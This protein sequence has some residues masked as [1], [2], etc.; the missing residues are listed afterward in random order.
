[1]PSDERRPNIIERIGLRLADGYIREATGG[2]IDTDEHLWRRIS[3]TRRQLLPYEIDRAQ[4]ISRHLYQRNPMAKRVVDMLVDFTIGAD[5]LTFEAE[6]DA[7][8][9]VIDDFW[10]DPRSNWAMRHRDVVRDL[11]IHG[12]LALRRFV[13]TQSG[14][15]RLGYIDVGRIKSVKSDPDDMLVDTTLVLARPQQED[16]VIPLIVWTDDDGDGRWEGDAFYFAVNRILGE[17]RGVPDLF[18][19]ADYVDGYDQI[20]FNA[21]ERSG[22]INAF[23]YDVT[24]EG[25]TPHDIVEWEEDNRE[26]PPP[27]S[28]RVHNEKEKWATVSPSL[29]SEDVTKVGRAVKNM[30]L[31]GAGMPE[32][33]FAEGDSA[34]RATLAAQGDPTYRMLQS[35][36]EF[37]AD[38]FTRIVSV[39]VQEEV[40]RRIPTNASVEFRV[41]LPE[42]SAKDTSSV[43]AAL[44]QLA[45][46][47]VSAVDSEF[48][49][50]ASARSLF[51][52]LASQVGVDLDPAE[53]EAAIESER[54]DREAKQAE[55]DAERARFLAQFA[56]D[57]E[58]RPQ[59]GD[60]G[61]SGPKA[62]PT[63]PGAP[64]AE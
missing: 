26:P 11:S 51:L 4:S 55:Q 30:G 10:T 29:G 33:W 45:A 58:E 52:T 62:P 5:G 8:Q 44:P 16:E 59:D 18:A 24:L 27:G 41:N 19:I 42:L 39:V 63:Q 56:Q 7:V 9:E 28:V 20:I 17:Q 6:D 13:N 23:I 25:A 48:I 2:T 46:A 57:D 31:G 43:S 61:P 38:M 54:A 60:R 22:L 37:L 3:D 14:R 50:T 64:A 40:G 47:L 34:N 36:Q 1:M 35:R 15:T 49:D 32:A 12:E 53:V 21:L